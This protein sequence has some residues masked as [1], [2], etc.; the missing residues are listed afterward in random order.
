MPEIPSVAEFVIESDDSIQ[1]TTKTNGDAIR[2]TGVSLSA[3][4]AAAL[5]YLINNEVVLKVEITENT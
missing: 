1:F 2:I 5:A 4:N 3:N